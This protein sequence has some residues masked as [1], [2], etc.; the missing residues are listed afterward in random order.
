MEKRG[1]CS[2]FGS[3]SV[4]LAV[5][6]A[7]VHLWAGW[8]DEH[9]IVLQPVGHLT[10]LAA[11]AWVLAMA[12]AVLVAAFDR[13]GRRVALVALALCVVGILMLVI[14]RPG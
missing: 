14:P 13:R 4:M 3:V 10:I 6:A 9:R 2:F 11:A 5:G 12:V 7:G 8:E 1:I